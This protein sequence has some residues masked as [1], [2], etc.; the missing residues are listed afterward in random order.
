MKVFAAN[1]RV[2]SC[3]EWKRA[4]KPISRDIYVIEMADTNNF[5]SNIPFYIALFKFQQHAILKGFLQIE[6]VFTCVGDHACFNNT[7]SDTFLNFF[8]KGCLVFLRMETS[9][10][11]YN[12]SFDYLF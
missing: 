7:F 8:G 3:D 6:C 5:F 9:C 12:Y 1:L 4:F 2:H 11:Q 10:K